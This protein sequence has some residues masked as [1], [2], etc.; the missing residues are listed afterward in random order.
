MEV[1][2]GQVNLATGYYDLRR[3]KDGIPLIVDAIEKGEKTAV[4]E[5][6]LKDFR[7]WLVRATRAIQTF[8]SLSLPSKSVPW[9]RPFVRIN[10]NAESLGTTA[11]YGSSSSRPT[12]RGIGRRPRT[13]RA[14]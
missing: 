14:N 1:L 4:S 11:G 7:G 3:P 13:K 2:I 5:R 10:A 12:N 9:Q 6:V 8:F